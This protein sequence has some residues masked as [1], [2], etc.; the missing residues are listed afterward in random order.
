MQPPTTSYPHGYSNDQ[1]G[2]STTVK[3]YF[4]LPIPGWAVKTYHYTRH[5]EHYSSTDPPRGRIRRVPYPA[6]L[7]TRPYP[8]TIDPPRPGLDQP[9]VKTRMQGL[10]DTGPRVFSLSH[11][12]RHQGVRGW[13]AI[14]RARRYSSLHS[15]QQNFTSK[16]PPA[17][18]PPLDPIKG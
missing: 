6:I 1:H 8:F 12:L 5:A 2:S 11:P 7:R 16:A 3:S 10:H 14:L 18:L 13:P 9:P 4:L 17:S 15:D